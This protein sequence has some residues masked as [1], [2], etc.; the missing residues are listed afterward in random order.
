MSI[1]VG[2]GR[3]GAVEP[4]EAKPI[5]CTSGASSQ[6]A[7]DRAHVDSALDGMFWVCARKTG[8]GNARAPAGDNERTGRFWRNQSLPN[9]SLELAKRSSSSGS[10]SIEEPPTSFYSTPAAGSDRARL[11]LLT[12]HFPPG[13]AAGALR[14]QK[15]SRYAAARGWGL[16]V[17]TLDPASLS[18]PDRNRLAEL[19]DGI[20]V[21]GVPDRPLLVERIERLAHAARRK[22]RPKRAVRAR[23][24]VAREEMVVRPL[25]PRFWIRAYD[26]WL[27][28]TR[29]LDWAVR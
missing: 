8:R 13:Q 20:R 24:S 1:Q 11:I 15:L 3:I 23:V 26:G 27:E 2:V 28:D 17:I 4:A 6:P 14:W 21:F 29:E 7:E 25:S 9:R 10:S 12:Y 16:D 19:P 22:L 18:A 5:D